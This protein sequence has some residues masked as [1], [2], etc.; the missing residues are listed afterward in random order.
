MGRYLLQLG[1]TSL[2]YVSPYH[3]GF[4]SHNR[5][6]GLLDVYAR[7]GYSG[8]ITIVACDELDSQWQLIDPN[9]AQV[10]S[11]LPPDIRQ[12]T[13]LLDK[14][15]ESPDPWMQFIARQASTDIDLLQIDVYERQFLDQQFERAMAC[16]ES[17]AW[18][19]ANDHIALCAIDY[20]RRHGVAVPEDLS[21]VGFDNT[22]EAFGAGL[23]TYDFNIEIAAS[24][25]LA[26][27]RSPRLFASS[28][29]YHEIEGAVISRNTGAAPA[30]KAL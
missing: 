11:M 10:S 4:W 15:K 9:S 7:A 8:N 14:A 27:I 26:F 29:G 2:S 5:L 17:T 20:L 28:A 23:T 1:H 22:V 24:R 30:G 3:L 19:C 25:M 13:L 21:V 16:R 18:V 12:A 6:E